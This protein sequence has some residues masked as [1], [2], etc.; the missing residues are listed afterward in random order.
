MG[1][2]INT[3]PDK[4]ADLTEQ[5]I[6][7]IN[8]N[9]TNAIIPKGVMGIKK[10]LFANNSLLLT[11]TF[12][13]DTLT[14]ISPYAFNSCDKLESIVF[15]DSLK[16]IQDRAFMG[17]RALNYICFPNSLLY[18]GNTAFGGCIGLT[19]I[20]LRNKLETFYN[21]AFIYCPNL[22]EINVPWAEG[23]VAN[24]P[25]GATNAVINYNY[26]EK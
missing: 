19:S 14:N 11:V 22:T 16:Y 24:A 26:V 6:G 21:N 2:A 7:L 3:M 15:P 9:A 10:Y 20:T 17:C 12:L 8:G 25:W 23:E 1:P 13:T 5:L 18:I 4:S